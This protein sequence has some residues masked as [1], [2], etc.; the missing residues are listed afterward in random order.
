[1]QISNRLLMVS[2]LVPKNA[3]LVD[4]GTDHGYVPIYLYTQGRISKA[5]A[6]D[7][8]KGPIERAKAHIAECGLEGAIETR[9]SD[10]MARLI[11][12]EGDAL[13]IAGMG[14]PLMIRILEQGK[15]KLLGN[16][17]LIL[18]PQSELPLVRHYLHDH[19]YAIEKEEMVFED[20]KYYVAMKAYKGR[21][22][23]SKTVA[24]TYG[25]TLLEGRNKVLY[26]YLC[27]HAKTLADLKETLIQANTPG[28]CVRLEAVEAEAAELLEALAYF[29]VS[30]DKGA[31]DE[32]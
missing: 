17:T 29:Q 30:E 12:G 18:Q 1:M 9:Q 2:D 5:L 11:P 24:Y 23:Y 14:G 19:G 6:M 32:K 16:E 22:Q 21:E 25:Q 26:Q 4:I 15:D 8:N 31:D 28:A 27:K 7:I 10:G 3:R 20:G 13:V